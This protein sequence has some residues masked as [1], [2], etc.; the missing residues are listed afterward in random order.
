M[1]S[2]YQGLMRD[3]SAHVRHLGL[4]PTSPFHHALEDALV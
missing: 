2:F 3:T 4:R 1:G